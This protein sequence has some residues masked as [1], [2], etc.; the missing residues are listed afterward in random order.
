MDKLG[1][2][3][4]AGAFLA[5]GI[6]SVKSQQLEVVSA[7]LKRDVIAVLPMGLEKALASNT[8]HSSLTSY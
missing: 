8:C 5:L 2:E 7:A 3:I 6:V 1:E 4:V